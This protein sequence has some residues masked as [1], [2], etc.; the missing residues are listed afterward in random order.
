MITV[1]LLAA[2]QRPLQSGI[3]FQ[4]ISEQG[5]IA[6]AAQTDVN[7]VL[8]FDVDAS[9]Y[10]RLAVRLDIES[11]AKAGDINRPPA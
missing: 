8:A 5:D 2:D 10:G 7:G 4:L 9:R 1:T 6:G 3:P 11:L